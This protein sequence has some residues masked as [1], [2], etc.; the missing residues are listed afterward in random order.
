MSVIPITV[1]PEEILI[2]ADHRLAFEVI[3]AFRS[4]NTNPVNTIRVL[5]RWDEENRLLAEFSSPV[6]LPFGMSSTLR[7]VEYVTFYE[8]SRIDFELAEPT[9]L[10][11]LLQDRFSFE[12]VEG[13]TRFRYESRF[14]V[15]G[16]VF[17]WILGQL[18]FKLMFKRHMRTHVAEL[19]ETIE[20]RAIH[21]RRY[22]IADEQSSNLGEAKLE[23][24]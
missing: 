8:P 10:L 4:P 9:G 5:N 16:W 20:A 21:S 14:G 7:T 15:A 3:A 23:I 11:C 19:R 17:G 24:L 6:P 12:A 13:G 22:P 2:R 18:V 1:E